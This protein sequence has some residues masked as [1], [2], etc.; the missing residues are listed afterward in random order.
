MH[1]RGPNAARA[2]LTALS[3][4]VLS[5]AL[6]LVTLTPQAWPQFAS[7]TITGV[8]KDSTGAVIPGASVTVT[9][10]Q[11]G[12]AIKVTT[13]HD[14]GFIA[15]NLAPAIYRLAAE[16]GG[17]KRLVIEGLKV[18][19]GSVL[20]QDLVLEIGTTAESIQVNGRTSLVETSNGAVGTTVQVSHVLEMPLVDRNVFNLVNLV[21]GA[22]SSA[23]LVSIGGGRLQTAQALVDGVNNTRGGLGA[24]GIELSPPVESMQ[25]FKVEV[26]SFGAEFGHTNGGVVNAVTRSG[27]NQFHGNLY[28][29]LRNDK[30]DAAGWGVDSLPP[31]RRN[32]FGGSL[33]GPIRKNKT[34]FF[35]NLDYLIVHDG[36]T[37]TRNAGLPAWRSGDFSTATRDAGGRAAAVIIYDPGTGSG[38]FGTP[39]NTTPFPNNIIPT[40]RLDP[41]AVKAMAYLPAPNRA[42]NNPFNNTGNWQENTINSITRAYHTI[43]LDHE[44]R[45][46]TKVFARYILTQPETNLTGYAQGYGAADPLG[47]LIDTRRQNL[48]LNM[49]HLFSPTRFMSFTAGVNRVF[50]DRKS[51]DC[52]DTNYGRMLGLPNTPGE[53]FPRFNFN[54]G[55]VPVDAIGAVGNANRIASFSNWDYIANFT[56]I[57]GKHTLK[58]GLQYSRFN[59]ND[60]SRASPGGIWTSNGQY[61]RGINASGAAVANTGANLAD[62]LLGRLSS[63][64]AAVSPSIGRRFQNYG[65]YFQDDWRIAPRLTL[66]LGLRYDTENPAYEV[67]GRMNNFDPWV[68]N[69]LA[70]TGDIPANAIGVVTFPNR[71]GQG[72]LEQAEFRS[73]L[74]IRLA[75]PRHQR[76]R[77][78]R[79]LRSFLWRFL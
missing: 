38:T 22:Y 54:G 14:G 17:F 68:P 62:F 4:P 74:R 6:M 55:L 67:A 76:H 32:N 45:Q 8:V 49:T 50:V 77:D 13:Q 44:L 69:P 70:G 34:F 19:V 16:V 65:A 71:N 35:Y 78:P 5:A 40:S 66:N 79:R 46:K 23:G 58:Y 61:T 60:H 1:L 37:N 42:P 15:P 20:T 63:I 12:A 9:E 31:L 30:L 53:V 39:I 59:G 48:A 56:D 29:F 73:T 3:A 51:G 18:D 27:S 36:V 52:C 24:N 25:E 7:G 47:V 2:I 28:E 41:V 75:S 33:G 21:P 72:K 11:T 26:N 10:M 43:R 57:R 64:T